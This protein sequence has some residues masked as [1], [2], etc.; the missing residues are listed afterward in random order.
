MTTTIEYALMAGGSYIS[1]R[2]DLNK[3]PVPDGWLQTTHVT[4]SSGFEA[5]AFQR[6]SEIVISYAGTYDQDIAGDI[7]ADIGLATG[8]GSQQLVQAA[9]YYLQVKAAN[10]GANIIFTGHSLGGGLA[11][12]IAVFFGN[13]AVTF[14]QAPFANSAEY[15]LFTED[16][17]IHLKDV[18][19]AKG[20][21]DTAL[22]G[23]TNFL[24]L[25]EANGGIPNSNLVTNINV[26]GE[27]LSSAPA[28][29]YDRIGSETNILN[30]SNGV[31]GIDLHSQALLA[32]FLQS[33]QTAAE[34]QA[35]NDVTF[36]LTDLLKMIFDKNLYYNDPNNKLNPQ[37]NF[38]ERLV[39]HEEGND[40]ITADAM[41]TRFT[42]DL[43]KLAQDGGLTMTDNDA[44]ISNTSNVSKALIAFAMQMYYEDTPAAKDATKQLFTAVTGGVQFDMADVSQKI[45]AAF[46]QSNPIVL[47]DAKGYKE[48]FSQYINGSG[49]SYSIEERNLINTMLPS[50]RDWYVQAGASGMD[51]TDDHN[52]HAFML[53]GAT[54]DT[55]T[56]GNKADLLVGNGGDDT[57]NGGDGD[58]VILGVTGND[59]L[60][61]DDGNDWLNGG[62]GSDDL[63]GGE[64]IDTLYGGAGTD[65]YLHNTSDGN[66]VIIDSDG[67]GKIVIN[68]SASPLSGGTQK[69]NA[70]NLWQ[71]A[72]KL[73]QYAIYHNGDG[74]DTLNI[75]LQNGERL[76]V[77]NWQNNQLGI[78]LEDG[79]PATITP[80][81]DQSDLYFASTADANIN[82]GAGNDVLVSQTQEAL[83]LNGGAGDDLILGYG[84]GFMKFGQLATPDKNHYISLNP[85][86]WQSLNASWQIDHTQLPTDVVYHQN[87]D[88]TA[89]A[90]LTTN[91]KVTG[92]DPDY[93][94]VSNTDFIYAFSSDSAQIL[95][96]ET[97]YGGTGN[98]LVAG[99]ATADYIDG[100]DDNDILYGNAGDDNMF[101]GQGKDYAFGGDGSDYIDGG[102]E[103]D[104]LVGG[105]GAD[106]LMGGAGDDELIAD[107]P[108]VVGT[109]A[110]PASTDFT[111]MGG[112]ILD[113]G[114]GN[115]KLFGGAGDNT[116]FG[117]KGDDYLYGGA[118][119]DKYIHNDGD[120][121][122]VIIDSDGEG[123]IQV[124]SG[125][126]LKGGKQVKGTTNLWQS[127]D[128]L[129]QYAIY[130]NGDGTDT[131]NGGQ[132]NDWLEGGA[133]NAENDNEWRAVA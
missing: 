78:K 106:Y 90:Y 11:A 64:G 107:L 93:G 21:T 36:K 27:F 86:S 26:Q 100:G 88:G 75:T 123:S 98:D 95:K 127:D 102:T 24:Q 126:P 52:R 40:S 63:N 60:N 129:T 101:G 122:D 43:W 84:N 87:E 92:T 115:D 112:D 7:A 113:G 73:T 99:S 68:G 4:K 131:L 118:G 22:S 81:T 132:G 3:F 5:V 33:D 82:S 51:T 29:L 53:G 49:S 83:T 67:L 72:D 69:D 47:S 111:L 42:A 13:Q 48:Y 54:N 85:N 116:L 57:L 71:S 31:S 56:G 19:L 114:I 125:D 45:L 2:P 46:T 38:L 120:G 28:T 117:G 35:L 16:V 18:L 14:D 34:G 17:A 41:V 39:R 62:Q 94:T 128:K 119:A 6:G 1:T 55:L 12:L 133:G 89:T 105:Y 79:T 10:P 65:T 59:T 91:W 77:K 25:R 66:D 58:D 23:L 70:T 103:D 109:N 76:F 61:G 32:A 44:A 108:D 97:L 37:E 96:G 121:N 8:F 15:N 9:E 104:T 50:M 30:S 124:K 20:Y 110:P 74:T 130:H 80:V